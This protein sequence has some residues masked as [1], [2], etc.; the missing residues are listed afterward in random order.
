MARHGR[1]PG[2][3]RLPTATNFSSGRRPEPAT[4]GLLPQLMFLLR[5]E[6][7]VMAMRILFVSI[8]LLT[9][10]LSAATQ[11][12]SSGPMPRMTDGKPNL[13]GVW[14]TGSTTPGSWEEANRGTGLG[15]TGKDPSAPNIISGADR[16]TRE[17]APY[18]EWAAKKVLE[19]YNK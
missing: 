15:G 19:S 10:S 14:Q 11:V 7:Q 1:M 17:G 4:V 5:S 12:N 16:Q 8:L 9:S 6:V 3:S 18:Q 13:T 2:K